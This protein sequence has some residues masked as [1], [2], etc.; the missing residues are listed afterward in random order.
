LLY[1]LSYLSL[2]RQAFDKIRLPSRDFLARQR[3]IG[4]SDS[5]RPACKSFA[6]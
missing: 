4:W 1:Q 5:P 2:F 6:V 3:R